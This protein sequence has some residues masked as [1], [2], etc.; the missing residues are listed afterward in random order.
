MDSH[1]LYMQRCLT[2]AARGAGRVAPNP[3]VGAVLVHDN[4]IIGEG[5]HEAF[6]G[7]HAEVNCLQSVVPADRHLVPDSTLY[8]SLEPCSHYGKTPPCSLRILQEHIPR[9]VVGCRDPF[10]SV[11]GSGI[12][13]LREAGVE[14]TEGLCEEECRAINCRFFTWHRLQR[15]Y[16]VLKWAQTDDGFIG[17]GNRDRLYISNPYTNHLVHRWRS[18]EAAILVGR[19]TAELDDPLLTNR[20]G[21]GG[22]PVR[23]VL[24]PSLQL[25]PHLRVFNRDAP[26]LLVHATDAAPTLPVEHLRLQPAHDLVPQLVQSLYKRQLQS[27][28]VE[29]GAALLSAF[30]RPGLY[31]EVRVIVSATIR[32]GAGVKAP[33]LEGLVL[34]HEETLDTDIIRYYQNPH[35][36]QTV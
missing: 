23:V 25:P 33:P 5:W 8:V 31:D 1:E 6:G 17:T 32:A 7:P 29:G 19:R 9:V 12:A 26:T 27:V 10:P 14:V 28:L 11:N 15:P 36:L 2:L 18:E 34:H 35:S 4:R 21:A 16:I 30:L 24:D 20:S 13:R 3:L 22:H